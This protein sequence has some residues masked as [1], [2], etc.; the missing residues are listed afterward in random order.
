MRGANRAGVTSKPPPPHPDP[1]VADS[2]GQNN[3]SGHILPNAANLVGVCMMAL[4][5]VKLLPRK[6]WSDNVDEMMAAA[7]VVFLLSVALSYAS[8]RTR[9]K[10]GKKLE[11]WAERVFL[12]GLGIIIISATIL[13][14]DI[15]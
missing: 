7:S 3:L 4:S 8:L 6:G 2:G 5:L 9:R 14:F 11:T 10:S 15:N 1:D 12:L 13:A